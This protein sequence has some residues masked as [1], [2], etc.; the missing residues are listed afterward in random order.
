M[1]DFV[2]VQY[3]VFLSKLH[4]FLYVG[5]YCSPLL[6]VSKGF[7]GGRETEEKLYILVLME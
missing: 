6:E 3:L 5:T 4:V 7:F 1:F 2:I